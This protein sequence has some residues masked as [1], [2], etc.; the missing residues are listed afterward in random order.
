MCAAEPFHPRVKYTGTYFNTLAEL[1]T[2]Y[3]SDA[4]TAVYLYFV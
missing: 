4:I 1:T 3:L 2:H